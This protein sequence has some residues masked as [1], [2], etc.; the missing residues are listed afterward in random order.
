VK[1][2]VTG[3]NGTIGTRL[4]EKLLEQGHEVVGIDR[5][6]NVFKQKK[7]VGFV[8]KID[9]LKKDVLLKAFGEE[10]FDVCVHLAANPYVRKSVEDPAIAFENCVTTSNVLELCRQN[11]IK[12]VFL[13]SSREV[14]GNQ[15]KIRK[16][17]EDVFLDGC[18]SPYTAS[19]F[20]LE[21][22][23]QS[24]HKC[25]GVETVILRFSNVYGMYDDSDRLIPTIIKNFLCGKEI[26]IFG[27]SKSLDF[28]YI[29]DAVNAV[30]ELLSVN[31]I[32]G[33]VFNVGSGKQTS[34]FCVAE[35]IRDILCRKDIKIVIT[36]SYKGEVLQYVSDISKIRKMTFYESRYDIIRGLGKTVDFY[37]DYFG[38]KK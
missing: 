23:G 4:C 10:S 37:L 8:K 1:V 27:Q 20:Y 3:A 18:E 30:I 34:L 24:Y 25:Y 16:C 13:A 12:K 29:D 32:G 26:T 33:Q 36:D 2:L 5:K 38:D 19:K 14:Y 31:G 9:L 7:D 21:A 22:L 28:T 11:S 6:D 35:F 15:D 17:E